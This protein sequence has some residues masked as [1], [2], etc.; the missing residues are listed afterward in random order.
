VIAVGNPLGLSNTLTTGVI[1]ATNRTLTF[2]RGIKSTGLIQTDAP[3]NQGNSGGPLLNVKGELIGI[4]TAIRADAQN[5][6]FAV[7]IGRLRQLLPMLLDVE[8]LNRILF[9]ATIRQRPMA[10]GGQV[11]VA[12][13][14]EKS[15]AHGKL[16]AGDHILSLDK[17]PIADITHYVFAMLAVREERTI[18]FRCRR[19]GQDVDVSIPVRRKPKPD[20]RALASQRMGLKLR[21]ITPKLA[22]DLR[23]PVREGLLVVG[24][25]RESPADRLGVQVKDILFHAAGY[26]VRDFES[27][28]LL[29]E[30]R[31]GGENIRVGILRGGTAV[32]VRM[33]LRDGAPAKKPAGKGEVRS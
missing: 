12:A 6:G 28:G 1:S 7:P 13:V 20:G 26:S 30:D 14:R 10:Q 2:R 24:V 15:P 22:K 17:R 9:G 29:L 4:N 18:A 31:K 19:N 16:Q 25:Q 3:I 21:E 27:L 32:I 11:Y 8:R 33:R 23:L 5:I